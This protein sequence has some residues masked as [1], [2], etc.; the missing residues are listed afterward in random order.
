MSLQRHALET[1]LVGQSHGIPN[2][3]A[4]GSLGSSPQQV[5][6]RDVDDLRG[7]RGDIGTEHVV[8]QFALSEIF[9]TCNVGPT[10]ECQLCGDGRGPSTL[11]VSNG[12]RAR[13]GLCPVQTRAAN[14]P[15]LP[16]R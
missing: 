2:A 11:P 6:A 12:R 5:D 3:I 10:F 9:A 16:S 8:H 13:A 15:T 4:E 14:A 7:A 1:T